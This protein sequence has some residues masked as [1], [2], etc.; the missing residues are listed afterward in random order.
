N[1]SRRHDLVILRV[2]AE[3][4]PVLSLG[5]S[6]S[7]RA[8]DAVVAI[9]HPLGLEDTVSNGLVSAVRHLDPELDVLQISAP[10]APGS[11]GGPLFNDH[12]D[13]IGITTAI[14]QGGQNLNLALPVKYVKAL[15]QNPEP[16]SVLVFTR[17][18]AALEQKA[19]RVERHVPRYPLALLTGCGGEHLITI[20]RT[21]GEAI[22]VG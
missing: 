16:V 22:E 12:G 20:T 2:E 21:L 3:K 15:L 10:I 19:P 9:G 18:M 17:A 7:V 4:L 1:A 13:V 5:D 14:V 11:S 8:G 6:D